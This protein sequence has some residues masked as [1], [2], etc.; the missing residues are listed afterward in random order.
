M[1][2][3]VIVVALVVLAV[4]CEYYLKRLARQERSRRLAGGR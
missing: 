3:V 4:G 2:T 1:V